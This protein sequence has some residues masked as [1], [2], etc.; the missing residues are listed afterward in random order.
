MDHETI[1]K[2]CPWRTISRNDWHCK[3]LVDTPGGKY[4]YGTH[5]S[6]V[7]C[8]CLHIANSLVEALRDRNEKL[9]RVVRAIAPADWARVLRR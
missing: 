6:D 9:S 5:C 2:G 4:P 1:A 8:A 7:N 3:A